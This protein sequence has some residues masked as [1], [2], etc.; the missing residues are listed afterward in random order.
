VLDVETHADTR[1][2]DGVGLARGICSS[3]LLRND[4]FWPRG[5]L[6]W[7]KSSSLVCGL[8]WVW[9]WKPKRCADSIREGRN[10]APGGSGVERD[11]VSTFSCRC[12]IGSLAGSDM[13]RC[14]CGCWSGALCTVESRRDYCACWETGDCDEMYC[15]RGKLRLRLLLADP[16]IAAQSVRFTLTLLCDPTRSRKRVRVTARK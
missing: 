5:Q 3:D 9:R 15:V 4:G 1:D 12:S 2:L 6:A 14:I 7:S 11:L 10:V 13:G 16:C 8:L